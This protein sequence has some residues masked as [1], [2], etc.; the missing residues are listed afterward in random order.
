MPHEIRCTLER[1]LSLSLQ[2]QVQSTV[3]L[4]LFCPN[5]K[6]SSSHPDSATIRMLS[7]KE[8]FESLKQPQ[9]YTLTCL[10]LKYSFLSNS[11]CNVNENERFSQEKPTI[12]SRRNPPQRSGFLNLKM[13]Q[14]SRTA[15]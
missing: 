9:Y 2:Q 13:H 8:C 12:F 6:H 15:K 11:D 5:I 14:N 10:L 4:R 7:Q 1:L 3:A